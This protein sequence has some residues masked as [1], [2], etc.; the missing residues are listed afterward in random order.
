MPA[1]KTFESENQ[2]DQPTVVEIPLPLFA[3]V[4]TAL[5]RIDR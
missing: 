1:S 2:N 4:K 5:P 3:K